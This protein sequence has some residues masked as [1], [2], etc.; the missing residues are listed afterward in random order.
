MPVQGNVQGG[1]ARSVAYQCVESRANPTPESLALR[2][3]LVAVANTSDTHHD[4]SGRPVQ[5]KRVRFDLPAE[6]SQR[7]DMPHRIDRY[8]VA[9]RHDIKPVISSNLP[10]AYSVSEIREL[11]TEEAAACVTNGQSCHAVAEKYGLRDYAS[12]LKLQ[13]MA[14]N[15][16]PA[17]RLVAS[18][19]SC[20]LIAEK[21]GI[22]FYAPQLQLQAMAIAGRA[23]ERVGN[24]E[25][26]DMV[27]AAHGI[28]QWEAKLELQMK[29]VHGRA[30]KRVMK[31]ES[32]AMVATEHAITLPEAK[33]KLHKLA[34]SALLGAHGEADGV[35]TQEDQRWLETA[36]I[37]LKLKT[38]NGFAIAH[39]MD[40]EL[41]DMVADA[42][43]IQGE[44]ARRAGLVK[45]RIYLGV[46]NK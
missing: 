11:A 23:G 2:G 36:K 41:W 1:N 35:V 34:T 42:H 12:Q 4:V 16:G 14:V 44:D 15:N 39:V 30:S 32:C 7:E 5:A 3:R 31:G 24:G 21:Y 28:E 22:Q 8:P 46:A 26:C 13:M 6:V 45:A 37:D 9:T 17:G 18:G 27:A 29:A 40:E 19:E 10:Q 25:P 20:G 38:A 33:L 43:G